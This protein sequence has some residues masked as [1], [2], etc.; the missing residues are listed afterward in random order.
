MVP[1]TWDPIVTPVIK[2][3]VNCDPLVNTFESMLLTIKNLPPVEKLVFPLVV[4]VDNW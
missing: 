3:P 4:P 2:V 1:E